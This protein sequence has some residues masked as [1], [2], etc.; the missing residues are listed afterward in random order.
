M[1]EKT[2]AVKIVDGYVISPGTTPLYP[3][4]HKMCMSS[5]L[6]SLLDLTF[7]ISSYITGSHLWKGKHL[8]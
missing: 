5:F 7:C 1:L 4:T 8:G 2:I 6:M 3:Y